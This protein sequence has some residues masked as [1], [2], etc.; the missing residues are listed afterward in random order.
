MAYIKD[1]KV[2]QFVY[3]KVDGKINQAKV[4][5]LVTRESITRY[6]GLSYFCDVM[7]IEIKLPNGN[8]L[9]NEDFKFG[10]KDHYRNSVIKIYP[11]I[12]DCRKGWHNGTDNYYID[13]RIDYELASRYANEFMVQ[14]QG[15]ELSAND[16]PILYY[17]DETNVYT[18]YLEVFDFHDNKEYGLRRMNDESSLTRPISEWFNSLK[19]RFK[20]GYSS[21]Y[22]KTYD[23]A[24]NDFQAEVV[25][26]EEQPKE[27]EI[28][29]YALY[30]KINQK[31]RI[32]ENLIDCYS[33]LDKAILAC[34]KMVYEDKEFE[35]ADPTITLD[36]ITFVVYPMYDDD[37]IGIDNELYSSA[38]YKY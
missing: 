26:F 32:D 25:M 28:K 10:S 29:W 36:Y 23:Q 24:Y 21:R 14:L 3:L 31:G 16:A 5:K 18:R 30:E 12:D 27:K 15:M 35:V 11:T 22:F 9:T 38:P 7:E 20:N 4:T 6:G 1:L 34:A 37:E 8:V 2:G 13:G 33:T 17:H 19:V